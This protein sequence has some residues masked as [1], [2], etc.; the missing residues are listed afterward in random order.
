LAKIW[1]PT[2]FTDPVSRD[3]GPGQDRQ[4]T[5]DRDS[6]ALKIAAELQPATVLHVGCGNGSLVG[7]LRQAGVD[8]C[9]IDA[10]EQ[11]IAAIPAKL[12]RFCSVRSLGEPLPQNYD[13]IIC[14][15][16]LNG[17]APEQLERAVSL[18]CQHSDDV[19]FSPP[20]NAPALEHLGEG[21]SEY[22]AELFA[23]NGF[24]RD[25][26]FDASFAGPQAV[27]FRRAIDPAR[28]IATY[29][30]RLVLLEREAEAR[31]ALNM[32]QRDDLLA[33]EHSIQ[34]LKLR[35]RDLE[36][37]WAELE[38]S[39]GWAVLQRLQ[40]LRARFAPPGSWREQLLEEIFRAFRV[41]KGRA[42]LYFV[43]RVGQGM[44]WRFNAFLSKV[45]VTAGAPLH[46]LTMQVDE[47][48]TRRPLQAHQASVEIVVCVHN[49]LA[50]VSRCL[51]SVVRH[52]TTPYS[53]ILVDDASEPET[54]DYLA[55]F[56]SAHGA[57]L[58]RNEEAKRYTRAANQ[59]LAR[60]SA[61]YV[62]LLNSD[63]IVTPEWLDRMVA[64]IESDP[65]IGIVG[66]LSNTA[67]WQSIPQVESE[68][69]WASNPLPPTM[70]PA[71][72]ARLVARYSARTYP[73]MPFLNG[74]CLLIRR[75]LIDGIGPF[76]EER[77]GQGYGE[78]DDLALRARKAGWQLALSDDAYVYHAQSR[79]YSSTTRKQ[80]S[81]RAGKVLA[82][83][84]GLQIIEEGVA[85]CA[86]NRVL[87]GIRVRSQAMLDRRAWVERGRARYAGLRVL[88]VLPIA[89]PGGGGNVVIDEARAMRDMG[90]DVRIFN[91][92]IYQSK[93]SSAYPDLEIP[94]LY[95]NEETLVQ[96]A[97]EY[98]AVI[99]THNSSVEWLA[100]IEPMRER[101][102][103]GYY[104][105][106]FEP[107]MYPEDSEDYR[108]AWNSYT[109]IDDLVRFT[110]TEWTAQ[111]VRR[112]TGADCTVVGASVNIDLFRPRHRQEPDWPSRALRISAMIRPAAP[113]R[114]PG[115]TME[116]LRQVSE[117][118][119]QDVE[120]VLF[121]TT[122]DDPGFA[123]LPRNFP[124]KLAGVLN[125]KQVARLMNEVDIFVDFSSHQAMGL[126][127][128][129]AMACGVAVVVPQRGGA[130]CF[131][132]HEENCL[133]V[134]TL[135][136]DACWQ[137]LQRLIEDDALRTTLQRNA[138]VDA[139]D[140]YPER[141]AFN[142]LSAL[143]D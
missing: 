27:R 118:Y 60:S 120:L 36:T 74:F 33:K 52:T 8:A 135:S 81:D 57:T 129:E 98:D 92:K 56:A 64:C 122:L 7:L 121:G 124:W 13:L 53:L 119:R 80:L 107:Y 15:H 126:T 65:Q 115:L 85:T 75:R 123:A 88:F 58:L 3:A 14:L 47:I 128:M 21:A 6:L 38:S 106:G 9:G 101:P 94:V 72:M 25:L 19:L 143:F 23:R 109:L 134:D 50:D 99:A 55:E 137:A 69:D 112:N 20:S 139:C 105:Q 111:E 35:A 97:R 132:R 39:P 29:E 87:Q 96:L 79:S 48:E 16:G 76:D 30:R 44:L 95:G 82:Q 86:N 142:I 77:F 37:R 12:E 59:G 138:L 83:K 102:V 40:I 54:R 26:E 41:H 110:K 114:E 117:R 24:F 104:I 51:E 108:R 68:G 67:S 140:F 2:K 22:W 62:V 10:S 78:E 70:T 4:A 18:I 32:S 45:R 89:A 133:V 66:P 93:F 127:A 91:L 125:Q 43:R 46:D 84:H 103:R 131:A 34:V 49:A 61:D 5:L 28:A 11:A 130:A 136:R 31:R 73:R 63:T 90:A 100:R 141:P 113:Y 116:L 71:D 17:L 1:E 42:P